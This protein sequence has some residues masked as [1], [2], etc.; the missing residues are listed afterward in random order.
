MIGPNL[1]AQQISLDFQKGEHMLNFYKVSKCSHLYL[2][3]S[4][5]IEDCDGKG[6]KA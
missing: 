3:L 4:T 2:L 1:Q 5:R 6:N